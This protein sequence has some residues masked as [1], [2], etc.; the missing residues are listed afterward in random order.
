VVAVKAKMQ[1]MLRNNIVR[2]SAVA[3]QGKVAS[4]E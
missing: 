3:V 2:K 4:T 1:Y